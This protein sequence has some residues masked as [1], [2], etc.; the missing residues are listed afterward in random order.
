MEEALT[1]VVVDDEE[2]ILK[3]FKSYLEMSGG[4]TVLTTDSGNK[5]LEMIASRKVDC[6]F[7]DLNMPDMDGIELSR[8]IHQHDNTIPMAVMTGYPTM[9]NAISTLKNGVVDFLTKP[10]D[11]AQITLTVKRMMREKSLLANNILLKEEAKKN[12]RLLAINEE[13]QQK[14]NEVEIMNSILQELDQVSTS[15]DLFHVLV[16]L[17]GRVTACDEA[18]CAVFYSE[19]DEYSTISSFYRNSTQAGKLAGHTHD[20]VIKR[21]ARDGIPVISNSRNGSDHVM[22]IPLKIRNKIFGLLK[23]TVG[24]KDGQFKEKDVYFMNFIAEKA[25]YLIENLALY[26]NIFDNLFATLYAFV[27][28]IE[29]RD[30]YTKQHSARVSH[31][32]KAIAQAVGCSREDLEKLHAAGYLHDIGKIGIPDN[33][34]LK[35]GSLTSEEF[36]TIKSHP[37]IASNIL[38]YFNLW[39]DEKTII[40]H[41][42][43]KFD[44][45]GY[46]D[47]LKGEDIPYLSRILSVADVYDALTAD[48]SYRAKMP[49]EKALSIIAGGSDSQFDPEFVAKFLE[50]HAQG[51]IVFNPDMVTPLD[52]TPKAA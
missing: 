47:A 25:S 6:C 18:H 28:T 46:P 26:E 5:A 38:G 48:R 16:N 44:G 34:L 23:L 12:A 2:P 21:V 10:V 17:S 43:E 9:D 42:H 29:A 4:H 24:N 20:D 14:I 31:Y 27:E 7:L 37:V 30:S 40:R 36:E 50:L 1:I 22:A 41:H 33:I 35:N 39:S 45:T 52:I 19:K 8:R 11:L 15:S 51:K 3:I 49:E 13:L 32:A